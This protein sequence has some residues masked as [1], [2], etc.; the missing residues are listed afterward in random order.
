M[1]CYD[2]C[3]L[4]KWEKVKDCQEYWTKYDLEDFIK[5]PRAHWNPILNKTQKTISLEKRYENYEHKMLFP[6]Q[7]IP[8]YNTNKSDSNTTMGYLLEQEKTLLLGR[9]SGLT[10]Y[11]IFRISTIPA[12]DI[13]EWIDTALIKIARMNTPKCRTCSRKKSDGTC[14][15]MSGLELVIADSFCSFHKKEK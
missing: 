4:C 13:K 9:L 14:E 6:D 7:V 1:T 8:A 11:E 10:N 12:K 2:D 15:I 3:N 5:I